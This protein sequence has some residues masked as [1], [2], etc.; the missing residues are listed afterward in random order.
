MN[1]GLYPR[2]RRLSAQG[3]LLAFASP[4]VI[5]SIQAKE[6]HDRKLGTQLFQLCSA[7]H[8]P[9][10]HGNR[11]LMAPAIAGLPEWYVINQL[12]KFKNGGRGAHPADIAGLRMRPMART[13][14]SSTDKERNSREVDLHTVARHVAELKPR[15][16]KD[17]LKGGD[18][19]RGKTIY[20]TCS[21]CHGPN[22][23]GNKELK[24]PT[25]VYLEDWYMLEQLKKFKHGL[26]GANPK[27]PEGLTMRPIVLAMLPD[28]Q[29]MKDVI[30]YIRQTA[31]EPTKEKPKPVATPTNSPDKA[32]PE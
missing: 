27:D 30:A 3:A 7:C 11:E 23:E 2:L 1:T 18:P 31:R 16:P 6:D 9:Q 28:E 14:D 26:R 8:G 5:P 17:E 19:V 10:G 25:Q 21:A 32:E 4:L 29:A 20:V 24:A 15:Q 12:R 22:S 13:L